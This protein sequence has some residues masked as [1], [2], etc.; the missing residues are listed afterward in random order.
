MSEEEKERHAAWLAIRC[1]ASV[2]NTQR[3][4]ILLIGD[5]SVTSQ[6]LSD[7]AQA[8]MPDFVALDL[9]GGYVLGEKKKVYKSKFDHRNV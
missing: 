7:Q 8:Q 6:K 1:A 4:R 3:N 9:V 2:S 5:S